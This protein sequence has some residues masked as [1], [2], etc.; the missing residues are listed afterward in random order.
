MKKI[1]TI[2]N[3]N[4]QQEHM[5]STSQVED[6]VAACPLRHIEALF[7][8]H[9]SKKEKIVEAG[10]RNPV[11]KRSENPEGAEK[12]RDEAAGGFRDPGP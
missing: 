2:R 6:E 12:E 5:W 3:L 11:R 4:Q 9:L 1:Y 7:Q 10:L 8:R